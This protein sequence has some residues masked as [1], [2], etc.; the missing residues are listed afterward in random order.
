MKKITSKDVIELI[1][2]QDVCKLK[3]FEQTLSYVPESLDKTEMEA[4]LLI[5]QYLLCRRNAEIRIEEEAKEFE[6]FGN[7]CF[8]DDIFNIEAEV[9]V[10]HTIIRGDWMIPDESLVD[11]TISS[12]KITTDIF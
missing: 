2:Q 12:L 5:K 11:V 9:K 8:E 1:N 3:A 4:L 10:R 7:I 6:E